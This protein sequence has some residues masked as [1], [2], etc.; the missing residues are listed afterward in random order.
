[1]LQ[2]SRKNAMSANAY[3]IYDL[4]LN[5]KMTLVQEMYSVELIQIP[6]QKKMTPTAKLKCNI[7][8]CPTDQ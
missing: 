2:Q 5:L 7:R 3:A 6:I 1:M 4:L 8:I